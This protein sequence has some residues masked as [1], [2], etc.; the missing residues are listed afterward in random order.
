M[1]KIT[2]YKDIN[3]KGDYK[4]LTDGN[5]STTFLQDIDFDNNI[6]SIK[7]DPNTTAILYKF[8]G[9]SSPK[10]VLQGPQ[11]IA[12]LPPDY[13]DSVSRIQVMT[14]NPKVYYNE[15]EF[16]GN[17]LAYEDSY[18]SGRKAYLGIGPYDAAKLNTNE[19]NHLN[20][21]NGI[22]LPAYVSVKILDPPQ[23]IFK[24]P[25]E[26]DLTQYGLKDVTNFEII[27]LQ[28][29]GK[30]GSSV[31]IFGD[32]KPIPIWPSSDYRVP[33]R[34]E[35]SDKKEIQPKITTTASNNTTTTSNNTTTTNNNNNLFSYIVIILIIIIIL[36]VVIY[37]IAKHYI[38]VITIVRK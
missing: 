38:K 22:V 37:I 4:I 20:Y 2:V 6:K 7:I 11:D 25:G 17:I 35:T 24:G 16:T 33:F 1:G 14:L 13:F 23:N 19:N 32:N 34:H 27:P 28:H 30:L 15:N 8:A 26:Y 9:N 5:Y 21:I 18:F 12:T 31:N 10:I 3:F 29:P 36:I